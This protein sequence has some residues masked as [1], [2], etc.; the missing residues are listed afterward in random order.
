MPTKCASGHPGDEFEEARR[1]ALE[2]AS[3]HLTVRHGARMAGNRELSEQNFR[4][5]SWINILLTPLLLILFA[6]PY[7]VIGLW[8]DF[9]ETWLY[10]GTFL[11]AFPLT[12]T[13][14]HGHVTIA[15][16]ALQRSH[17]SRMAGTPP[18]GIRILWIRPIFFTT[19]FRLILLII[20]LVM[21][22]S[23]V[24]M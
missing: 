7:A 4:R 16:G 2:E 5:I 11:F 24:M 22:I 13:I 15:L 10:A 3:Q 23:G 20:S 6:W 1:R 17:Y 14:I 21:L 18:L 12:L 8:F 19:R 9:P